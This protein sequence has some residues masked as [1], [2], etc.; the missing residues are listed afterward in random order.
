MKFQKT[1]DGSNDGYIRIESELSD[2]H[3]QVIGDRGVSFEL[4]EIKQ[5]VDTL[6]THISYW[7]TNEQ[8]VK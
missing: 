1:I 3:I 5:I 7:E 6:L 4:D 8:T 2:L